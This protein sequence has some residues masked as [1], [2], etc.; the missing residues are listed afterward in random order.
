MLMHG[1]LFLT[2]NGLML[3]EVKS[4]LQKALRRKSEVLAT[5]AAKELLG[6]GK[7]QLPWKSLLTY[8]F[9]DH[10]LSSSRVTSH[11]L[12]CMKSGDKYGAVELL[13]RNCGTCRMAAC[14]PVIALQSEYAPVDW[15]QGLEVHQDL[16]GLVS[17][18]N[19]SLNFDLLLAHLKKAWLS[20]NEREL[21][22]YI[23]LAT[24]VHDEE[25]RSVTTKGK[26]SIPGHQQVKRVNTAMVVLSMLADISK[27]DNELRCFLLDCIQLAATIPDPP[28]RLILCSAVVHY[29][30]SDRIR[31]VDVIQLGNLDWAGVPML[32]RMPSW[33][34]DKHTFR[35]KF[36]RGTRHLLKKPQLAL[37]SEDGLVEFHGERPKVGVEHFF[38]EGC[39]CKDEVI[40]ENPWWE[41][42]QEIYLKQPHRLQKTVRMTAVYYRN[43]QQQFPFIFFKSPKSVKTAGCERL[44]SEQ[45]DDDRPQTSGMSSRKRTRKSVAKSDK[46]AKRQKF[47]LAAELTEENASPVLKE[48]VQNKSRNFG[49]LPLLQLPTGS[50]KVYTRV[51]LDTSEVIK[52]PY[53]PGKA[54]AVIFYHRAMKEVLGDVHTLSVQLAQADYVV[55]PLC[56]D[57]GKN[58]EITQRDFYDCIAKTDI[59]NG[60]FVLRESLGV[61]QIHKLSCDEISTLPA[62]FW[63][64][65]LFRYV[66]NIGDSGLYNAITDQHRTFLYGIDLDDARK[67]V[68]SKDVIDLLFV[69]LPR[70]ELCKKIRR[71]LKD[72]K[73]ELVTSVSKVD[74]SG[75]QRLSQKYKVGVDC[76]LFEKRLAEVK[77]TLSNL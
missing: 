48:E 20:K 68:R 50:A 19:G 6:Y 9:E 42:T 3:D 67:Q 55:F 54:D 72:H 66:L 60:T 49:I 45:S 61:L 28:I 22:C 57:P 56:K 8:L 69:K 10:C 37:L 32:N 26:L 24:M 30:Y 31:H 27:G 53:R 51:D 5:Q 2:V 25:N 59:K 74:G 29:L 21:V 58:P 11:L 43:L 65:F 44:S 7:D 46:G 52:G 12:G 34:V 70:K 63:L 71:L 76:S 4:L 1:R 15:Q 36:G 14:L 35:G 13:L 18:A 75:L 40:S 33:A 64:H 62:T 39:V 47:A 16:T 23:K 38:A 41:K 17:T 73:D 77:R